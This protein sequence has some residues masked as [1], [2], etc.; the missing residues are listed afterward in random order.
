MRVAVAAALLLFAS[1]ILAQSKS[2]SIAPDPKNSA[3]FHADDTFD[4]FDGKTTKVTGTIVADPAKPSAASVDFTV[5]LHSLD[6]GIGLRNKEMREKYLETVKWPNGTFKSVGVT[7]P[8]SITPNSPADVQ[9]TGDLTVHNITKR[10]T[11]PVR[12]VLI[13]DNRLHAST[14]FN[15]RM[16]DYG[17]NVPHN[18]LMTVND[19]V[20]VRIDVWAVGK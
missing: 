8:E 15:I 12:V 14:S 16:P 10:I 20:T 7:G 2:Y 11:I 5:D 1:T 9:V 18:I 6:T 19:Q 13:P 4:K 3:T 17:I